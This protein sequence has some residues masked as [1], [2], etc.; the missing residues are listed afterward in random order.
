M[1][2]SGSSFKI[3]KLA[4]SNYFAWEQEIVSV[5]TLKYLDQYIEDSQTSFGDDSD[6]NLKAKW[7][8]G[9]RKAQ[10]IIGLSMSDE[11]LKHLRDSTSTRDMW[12]KI[13]NVVERHILLNKLTARRR[14][15]IATMKNGEKILAYLNR[16]RHLASILKSMNVNID[17][18]EMAMAVLNGLPECCETLIVALDALGLD[19][20]SFPYDLVKSRLL[21]EEQRMN[22]RSDGFDSSALIGLDDKEKRPGGGKQP[23]KCTNCGHDGHTTKFYWEKLSA[24]TS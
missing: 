23:Y 4:D 13:K 17:D 14:F 12:T 1:Y 7:N 21:Q 8:R 9:D 24:K 20:K 5:L 6:G 16:A 2:D 22:M 15:Y 19:D 10:A 18:K 11:H 3:E